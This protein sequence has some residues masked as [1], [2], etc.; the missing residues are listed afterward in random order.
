MRGEELANIWQTPPTSLQQLLLVMGPRRSGKKF[1]GGPGTQCTGLAGEQ[2]SVNTMN[3]SSLSRLLYYN[4]KGE[5]E[6]DKLDLVEINLH[7]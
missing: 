5:H 1:P 6:H 4:I 7:I 3:I 2:Q